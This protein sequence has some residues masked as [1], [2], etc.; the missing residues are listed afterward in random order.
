MLIGKT[1]ESLNLEQ[2]FSIKL[3]SI[4][5]YEYFEDSF[6]RTQRKPNIQGLAEPEQIVQQNDVLVIYGAN[7][8]IDQ[9]LRRIGV[10]S[11]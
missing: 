1:V 9:F 2:K 11:R 5:H 8:H 6:G 10:M 3:L 7:K 4:M